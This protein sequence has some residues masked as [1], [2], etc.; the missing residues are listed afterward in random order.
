M[1]KAKKILVTLLCL[2]MAISLAACGTNSSS[3][4]TGKSSKK[5]VIAEPVHSI[6]YLPLYLAIQKGYFKDNGLD[7]EVMTATGGGHVTSVVSGDAWGNIGGPESNAMGNSGSSDPIKSVVNVVNRANVY[8]MGATSLNL[9]PTDDPEKLKNYLKGKTIAAGRYG[10]SLNALTRW[11]LMDIGLDPNKDVKLEEPADPAAVVSLV[12]SGKADIANGAEPQ[13]KNGLD[14]GA[15]NE[16]FYKFTDLGDYAYSVLSV[17]ES[18]IKKSP[19]TVQAFVDAIVKALKVVNDDH[20]IAMEVLQKEFSTTDKASL[21]AALDR[22]YEDE[23]W[24]KDGSISKESVAKPLD[25]VKKTGIYKK[26][27][28]YDD[29]VDMQFVNKTNK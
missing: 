16:P 5:I 18:T 10:G 19:E 9:Q 15:W 20:D 27:Y 29:L 4:G 21:Q 1:K 28:S 23:L 13:I 12:K 24:S 8:L 25:V 22:A 7:V 6:G 17:K 11:L 3:K 2:G 26:G 14:S